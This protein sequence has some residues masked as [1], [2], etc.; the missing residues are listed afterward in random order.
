MPRQ[1]TTLAFRRAIARSLNKALKSTKWTKGYLAKRL[2]VR[3]STLYLYL[4]AEKAP[5]A[6]VL[7]RISRICKLTLQNGYVVTGGAFGPEKLPRLEM[8]QLDLFND[9]R[10][11]QPS[12][13]ETKVIRKAGKFLE[14]RVRIK[15]AS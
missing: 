13:I 6:E 7:K 9:L 11:I 8:K 15:V 4:N 10:D 12:Q 3:R 14:F 2:G 5:G 1:K